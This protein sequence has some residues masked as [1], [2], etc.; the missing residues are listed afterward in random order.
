MSVKLS[1]VEE[2]LFI[3]LW[4]RAHAS[5][6]YPSLFY[7]PKAVE[8]VKTIDYDF[9]VIDAR[10]DPVILL[11]SIARARQCDAVLKKYL[12]EHP[13]ASVVDLGAGLDTSFYRNDNGL[14]EWYDLDLPD[15]VAIRTQVLPEMVRVHSIAKSLLDM[16]WCD[17]LVNIE[18]GVFV[19]AGAVLGYFSEGDLK[20]FFS[21]LADSLPGVQMVFTAYSLAEVS[22]INRSLQRVGMTS[23]AMKWAL[24]DA[25]DLTRWDDRISVVD[26]F[27]FFRGITCDPAWGEETVRQ[28]RAIDGHKRMRIV[29]VRL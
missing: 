14:L 3:P 2:T 21:S 6:K 25:N 23:V 7:D 24:E 17:D 9:S 12:A 29:N 11:A 15:V 20:T 22:L 16:S 5:I 4:C 8:L 27:S 18:E 19:I 26:E 28:I 10:L 1:A 13:R